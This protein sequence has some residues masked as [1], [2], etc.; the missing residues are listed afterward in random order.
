MLC[1]DKGYYRNIL[2][3]CTC[4]WSLKALMP[5]RYLTGVAKLP[6]PFSRSSHISL[7]LIY[8]KAP[9]P[10]CYSPTPF[11]AAYFVSL[12]FLFS[13]P[14]YPAGPKPFLQTQ[15][16]LPHTILFGAYPSGPS[17]RGSFPFL[18]RRP[19]SYLGFFPSGS[20]PRFSCFLVKGFV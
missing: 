12:S 2:C 13:S 20:L 14:H 11:A 8:C 5:L 9:P 19:A 4:K 7:T 17:P 3:L 10:L 1:R 16:S 18:C 6:T 15:V